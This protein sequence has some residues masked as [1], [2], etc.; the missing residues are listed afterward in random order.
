MNVH[1]LSGPS[2]PEYQTARS[3]LVFRVVL[4]NLAGFHCLTDL[5]D[6]DSAQ[7]TLVDRMPGELKLTLCNLVAY[8]MD[9]YHAG[10][11]YSVGDQRGLLQKLQLPHCL[12]VLIYQNRVSIWIN[13]HKASRASRAFVCF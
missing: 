6:I 13:N 7:N 3:I 8:L 12:Y 4:Y 10:I 9:S 2:K 5:L 11:I 1:R